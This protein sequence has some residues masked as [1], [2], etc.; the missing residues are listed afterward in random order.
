MR[1]LLVLLTFSFLWSKVVWPPPPEEPRVE[2]VRVIEKPE[3]LGVKKG[4]WEKLKSF[5]FGEEQEERI[6]KPAGVYADEEL[7][8]VADQGLKG[9]LLVD[10]KKKKY[11]VVYGFPSPVDLVRYRNELFV[12]DS[13]LGKVLVVSLKKAKVVGEVGTGLLRRPV[14]LALD[15]ARNRLYVVDA[16][17]NKV[18]VFD[19]KTKKLLFSFGERLA[20][21]TYC[22]LDRKGNLYV[23]DSL[24]AKVRIFSPEGKLV[25]SFGKRGNTVGSFAN[26]RGIT[27][28]REGH[29]YVGDTL[30]SVIQVFD[31]KGR[32]LLVIGRF[33]KGEGEFALPMDLF[34]RGDHIYVADSYNARVVVLRY[35]GG[36]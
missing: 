4:F 27:V 14:G 25:F 13:V 33:G 8:A 26:P 32:L 35:L 12:S 29:V 19:P 31:P 6:I 20:R 36:K 22:A 9:V 15:H 21:P 11:R 2:W 23:S 16:L 28:D 18:F 34:R 24:N 7:F 30:F 3:D 10:L 1:L 17:K 5:L